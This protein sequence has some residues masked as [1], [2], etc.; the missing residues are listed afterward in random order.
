MHL[1][2]IGIGEDKLYTLA[3]ALRECGY[4]VSGS[5]EDISATQ[6]SEMEE[7]GWPVTGETPSAGQIHTGLEGVITGAHVKPDHPELLK[8][9]DLEI[10]IYSVPEFLYEFARY[11]TRV[12]IGGDSGRAAIASVILHVLEYHNREVDHVISGEP[13][14]T[15]HLTKDNDFILL[16]GN[17]LPSSET[18][19]TPEFHWYRPNIALLSG[20]G[21]ETETEE[22]FR[23]FVDRIVKGG[24]AVYNEEDEKL[25]IIVE[26]SENPIRKHPYGRPEYEEE[27]G[28]IILDTPEGPMPLELPDELALH[29]LVGAKWICQ[30]MGVDE[31]D[32]YEAIAAYGM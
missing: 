22:H 3:R 28:A 17:D 25:K 6:K 32:F 8:A 29:H 16:T 12:V 24:I 20:M 19:K 30:H 21:A 9:A 11:K 18:D 14:H 27:N 15:A 1:H 10:K 7:E 5:G 2:C 4:V 23:I 26:T 31:D 13:E